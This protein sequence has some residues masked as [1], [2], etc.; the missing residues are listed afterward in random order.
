MYHVSA[1]DVDERM[2]NVLYYYCPSLAGLFRSSLL[3]V[4]LAV[5]RS[6]FDH[7]SRLSPGPDS[8]VHFS[9]PSLAHLSPISL[10]HL[11]HLA[12]LAR[13]WPVVT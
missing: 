11:A 4:F 10:A 3:P 9:R 6:S 13:P 1:Q 7:L 5:S 12:H 2:I 8:L